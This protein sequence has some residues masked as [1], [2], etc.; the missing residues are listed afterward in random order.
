MTLSI[1]FAPAEEARLRERAAAAGKDIQTFVRDAALE[2][3]D[4]PTLGEILGPIH[5]A[6]E[7][8]GSSLEEIDAMGDQAKREARQQRRSI[9]K[10]PGE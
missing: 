6:T 5:A 10:D 8:S 4:R 1:P 9:Q 7:A 3:A 2:K